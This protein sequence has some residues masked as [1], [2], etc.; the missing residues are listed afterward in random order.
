MTTTAT[1]PSEPLLQELPLPPRILIVD[2]HPTN[3]QVLGA[4]LRSA[5]RYAVSF[6]ESGGS[7][8]VLIERHPPDLILLDI[9]MPGMDGFEV[10]RQLKEN[11]RYQEIPILFLTAEGGRDKVMKGFAVGG[12]DY[13]TKPFDT[14]VLQA[15]VAAQLQLYHYRQQDLEI[16]KLLEQQVA[17]RTQDL[18][19]ALRAKDQF[20][21]IM[22]HEL[23]TPLTTIIGHGELLRDRCNSTDF[24]QAVDTILDAGR[25]QL[26]LVDDILDASRI[27]SGHLQ[28][29]TQTYVL[30]KLL[31]RIEQRFAPR[32]TTHGLDF[33]VIDKAE[34]SCKLKGDPDR[35][36]QILSGL[37]DN[38]IKFTAQGGV[39]VT[40][41]CEEGLLAFK[42]KDTGVGMTSEESQNLF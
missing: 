42:V 14:E 32:A 38:A 31:Q 20:L 17:A 26:V 35:I 40:A 13:I 29:V 15:R 6:A 36:E 2:D 33:R 23:R 30:D 4:A 41:Q 3:L 24:R 12:A 27:A 1:T 16:R 11:P 22:S 37:V 25:E 18:E 34:F 7:A 9:N 19:R 5:G 28:V 10:C 8:L 21:A 39:T